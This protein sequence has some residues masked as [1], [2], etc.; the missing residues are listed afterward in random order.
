ML[1]KQ[2][3][4]E[5]LESLMSKNTLVNE[6]KGKHRMKPTQHAP[7]CLISELWK[8][9]HQNEHDEQ[10]HFLFSS[11]C[12]FVILGR[13]FVSKVVFLSRKPSFF[14]ALFSILLFYF[15]S[16]KC[17][18]NMSPCSLCHELA[19]C[20]SQL[21]STSSRKNTLVSLHWVNEILSYSP[22]RIMPV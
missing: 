11:S 16:H 3:E 8:H 12:R 4:R 21:I 9:A 7:S 20:H 6:I 18:G 13:A 1:P 2:M 10:A 22:R 15:P 17:K 5:I 19:G 14:P